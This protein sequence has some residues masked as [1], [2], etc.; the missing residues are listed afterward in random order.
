MR[1][2]GSVLRVH[3]T[4][5]GRRR[6]R[7]S[8]L[9]VAFGLALL[10]APATGIRAADLPPTAPS[11]PAT[12]SAPRLP[13]AAHLPPPPGQT[14]LESIRFGGGSASGPSAVASVSEDGRY[15]AFMS[16]APDLVPG[17]TN[18]AIDVFVRDRV[19]GTTIRLPVPGGLPVPPLGSASDPSISADGGVV[20]FTYDAPQAPAALA[21]V[22]PPPT[23]VAWNR[24]TGATEQVA[25]VPNS[26]R[27]TSREASLS[28]DGRYVA[29]TA[30]WLSTADEANRTDVFVRD[31]TTGT[32]TL[33]SA[34]PGGVP[35]GAISSA[36]SISR[37]GRF[38]AFQSDAGDLVASDDNR[39]T[40]VFVR[41][42]QAGTTEVV[43]VVAAGD[44]DGHSAAPAISADG[45]YVAFESQAT[46]LAAGVTTE[47]T[48]VFRRD[49]ASGTTALVSV[50]L[51]GGDAAG[52]SGQAAI[53]GDGRIVAF[54]STGNDLV[55]AAGTAVTAAIVVTG[56]AEVYARDVEASETIRISVALAGGPGGD[57][58]VGAAIG[59]NGR[60]FAWTSNSPT[61]VDGDTNRLGD[62]FLRDLPPVPTLAPAVLDF[63][64]RATGTSGPPVAA[65]LSNAG[66]SPLTG[67]GSTIDG[68]AAA[69][70]AVLF[71]GC[72]GRTLR[73]TEACT[74]TVSYTPT[75]SGE[76]LATLRVSSDGPGTPHT[77]TLR[78]GGSLAQLE[79]DPPNGKPG[80]VT[81]ATGAGFPPGV[82]VRL[83][84]S[85]GIT[86]KLPPVVADASGA[87]RVQVLVFHNDI[88]GQRDLVASPAD[89]TSFPAFGAR[90]TVSEASGQ[91]PRFVVYP[92]LDNPPAAI[93]G[94][95]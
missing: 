52:S 39:E 56:P 17:D 31:R 38:V 11:D 23:V 60:Y 90:F 22:D 3:P 95:R 44:V 94:R 91:P 51:S 68:A 28:G 69:D 33:V 81:I 42:L 67:S 87:F 35:G 77:A 36:P 41:D 64:T 19:D 79:L 7:P 40:D 34:T 74:V 55:A 32:T 80:I 27:T 37:D 12:P 4:V 85:R 48:A 75:V 49:R 24:A 15:V 8:L 92:A 63:G 73:R 20:A 62:I 50:G 82:E 9:P 54:T 71:D 2:I 88:V 83:A 59:G 89:G 76:R 70:F 86:P 26:F 93:V 29:F 58:N 10:V 84:W 1:S 45:R 47:G 57:Q 16:R 43:S 25:I 65:I 30:N 66:W 72:A 61:L 18:N 5:A 21:V 53:S 46:N 6:A 78:G 14:S 13:L